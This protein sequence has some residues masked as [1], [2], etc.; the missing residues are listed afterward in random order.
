MRRMSEREVLRSSHEEF[1]VSGA[2]AAHAV[3]AFE[4]LVLLRWPRMYPQQPGW[5][6]T[7]QAP[8]PNRAPVF[9]AI[10]IVSMSCVA[11]MVVG[12][13]SSEFRADRAEQ[14]TSAMQALQAQALAAQQAQSQMLLAQ[15][16]A[17]RAAQQAERQAEQARRRASIPR[18]CSVFA[19]SNPNSSATNRGLVADLI[20]DR[21][22]QRMR[23]R[24]TVALGARGDTIEFTGMPDCGQTLMT[25]ISAVSD[26]YDASVR[27]LC[28]A[29]GFRTVTC[30][31][32]DG[33]RQTLDLENLCQCT[34][35]FRCACPQPIF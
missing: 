5:G 9:I 31:A 18:A 2:V 10:G 13:I 20:E 17:Q 22:R 15:Q 7:Y 34:D 8:P 12:A 11:C 24:A 4:R 23:V 14:Q 21:L 30:R 33:A 28:T 27:S 6:P 1:L 16:A 32:K 3:F 29:N 26:S 35:R 25:A 19:A